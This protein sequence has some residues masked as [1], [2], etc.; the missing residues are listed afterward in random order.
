MANKQSGLLVTLGKRILGFGTSSSGCCA[1]PVA[2]AVKTPEVKTVEITPLD[3]STRGEGCCAPSCCE[4]A[5][6]ADAK[7]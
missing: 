3:T 2:E 7:S 6:P 4:S 1:G 5:T